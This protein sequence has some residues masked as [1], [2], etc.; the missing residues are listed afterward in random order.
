MKQ[1]KIAKDSLKAL[2]NLSDKYD[3]EK[4]EL[5]LRLEKER[6]DCLKREESKYDLKINSLKQLNDQLNSKLGMLND[7]EEDFSHL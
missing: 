4:R 1:Q 2:E 7:T 5:I 6:E 3:R